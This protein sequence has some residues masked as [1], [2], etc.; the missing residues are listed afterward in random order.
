MVVWRTF[1]VRCDACRYPVADLDADAELYGTA[2]KFL[3]ELRSMGWTF[4]PEFG[5]RCHVCS[6]NMVSALKDTARI[7]PLRPP[8]APRIGPTKE[9][10][11]DEENE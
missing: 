8:T 9:D 2:E 6:R 1:A 4:T 7:R 3:Q 11:D 5:A 10:E